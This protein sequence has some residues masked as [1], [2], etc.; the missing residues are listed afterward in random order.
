MLTV[1]FSFYLPLFAVQSVVSGLR[2]HMHI[3]THHT[4]SSKVI[5]FG[6]NRKQVCDFLLVLHTH[7]GPILHRFRDIAGY[8]THDPTP[9]LFHSNFG[10]VPVGSDR[11]RWGQSEQVP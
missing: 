11:P 10:G 9:I 5:D 3:E 8:C 2:K 4:R 7:F 1:D 6:T